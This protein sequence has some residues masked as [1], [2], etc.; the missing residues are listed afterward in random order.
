LN[1]DVLIMG[2]G[3]AGSATALSLR[4]HA[5]R[6][7]TILVE[8]SSY[9]KNRIGEVLPSLARG[10]LDHLGVWEAF[11]NENHAA[12]HSTLSVW[13]DAEPNDNN[14]IFSPHGSGWHLDRKEFDALLCD[15]T[16][17][18]GA[19]VLL[20][21]SVRSFKRTNKKTG[22]G[23]LVTL[24]DGSEKRARFI[25]DASGRRAF[26][27]R[28]MGA[29]ARSYDR[30]M[31]FS[32]YFKLEKDSAPGTLVEAS[33]HGWWYTAKAGDLRMVSYLTDADIGQKRGL[34]EQDRWL[35]DFS[36]TA[37]ISKSAGSAAPTGDALVR[38]ANSMLSS[39]VCA[40]GR[41]FG[42]G[43]RSALI[44]GDSQIAS[45]GNFCLVRDRRSFDQIRRRGH[46]ALR[47]IYKD[48]ICRVP[49][50]I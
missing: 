3:P 6:L 5:P 8:A 50:I 38:P 7:S 17:L 25:V 24:S 27:A 22:G 20:G 39:N 12:A 28:K 48:R 42:F 32:R 1:Y 44:A 15:Q 19:D 34:N 11:Q 41:G 33:R 40:L 30:L 9:D 36:A 26:F 13:G 16:A 14:F 35:E 2:G 21:T 43:F 31:S 4:N 10:M 46:A 29:E 49:E 45:L 37:H 18:A 23:W 47:T